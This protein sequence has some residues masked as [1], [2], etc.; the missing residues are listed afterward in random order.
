MSLQRLVSVSK[1]PD[2]FFDVFKIVDLFIFCFSNPRA[3]ECDWSFA[4]V[5]IKY[6]H[7]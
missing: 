7:G 1:T 2:I 6:D 4:R 5:L 3:T